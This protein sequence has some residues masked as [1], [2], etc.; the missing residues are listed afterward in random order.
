MPKTEGSITGQS[1]NAEI[2]DLTESE[3]TIT[4]NIGVTAPAMS[5]EAKTPQSSELSKTEGIT[6]DREDEILAELKKISAA[7]EKAPATSTA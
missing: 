7:L 4:E 1:N 2:K 3:E 5:T 6:M